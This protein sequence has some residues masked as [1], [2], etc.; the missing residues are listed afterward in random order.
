MKRVF[1]LSGIVFLLM[2][3]LVFTGR[4]RLNHSMR[5]S[6]NSGNAYY[7]DKDYGKAI[8]IYE[9]VLKNKPNNADILYNLGLTAYAME[10]YEKAIEYYSQSRDC[11]MLLGNAYYRQGSRIGDPTQQMQSYRQGLEQYLIS[12][13][14]EPN[15]IEVKYNYE[16]LKKLIDDREQNQEQQNEKQKDENSQDSQKD[17]NQQ[18]QDGQNEN[19]KQENQNKENDDRNNQNSEKQKNDQKKLK[20]EREDGQSQNNQN[21]AFNDEEANQNQNSIDQV[22]KMLEQQEKQSL[23]NNQTVMNKGGGEV[24]DW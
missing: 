7:N 2:T 6:I 9:R 16:L 18:N 14:A 19:Q 11:S 8:E 4:I 22:L 20:N 13:K 3:L 12:I 24:N 5:S 21:E 17:K 10:D 15:N 23:K 1:I